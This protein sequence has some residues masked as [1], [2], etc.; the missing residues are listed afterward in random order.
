VTTVPVGFIR[1]A[2]AGAQDAAN[3]SLTAVSIPFYG[4][5][6]YAGAVTGLAGSQTVVVNGAGWTPGQ[7]V[8]A[9]SFFRIKSGAATGAFFPVASNTATELLLNTGGVALV[10]GTP[11]G[12]NQVPVMAG[13]KFE[14]VPANTLGGVFGS[15]AVPFQTGAS[16]AVADNLLFFNGTGWGVYYHNG[17]VW[18]SPGVAGDQAGAVIPPDSAVFVVRRS[19]QPL[20]V[21]VAGTVPSTQEVLHLPLAASRFVGSR[22]PTDTTLAGLGLHQSPHW[23]SGVSASQADNVL[24]WNGLSGTWE[25]FYH[26]GVQ[27]RRAG[28]F[29]DF[30]AHP[31]PAGS[32]VFVVRKPGGSGD[33]LVSLPLPYTF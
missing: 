26:N 12:Q 16:A 6:L 29:L 4:T 27:W 14:V 20:S 32:G 2:V 25:S 13:D 3:P 23:R 30:N 21:Y 17:S 28:S 18:Q 24:V 10:G 9:P 11:N 31:V 15:V 5:A 22:F 19:I 7:F 8:S 33:T 1:V